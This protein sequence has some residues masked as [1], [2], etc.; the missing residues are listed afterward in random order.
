MAE[1][2][3]FLKDYAAK[4]VIENLLAMHERIC[5]SK[6]LEAAMCISKYILE[7]VQD[8]DATVAC[9]DLIPAGIF[10]PPLDVGQLKE[11][12]PDG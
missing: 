8:L 11:V 2:R 3:M 5:Q 7:A 1:D 6:D 10:L 4:V 9:V 12:P